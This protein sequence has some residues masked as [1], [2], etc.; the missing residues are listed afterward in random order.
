LYPPRQYLLKTKKDDWPTWVQKKQPQIPSIE[1]VFVIIAKASDFPKLGLQNF[2]LVMNTPL[3]DKVTIYGV[4][5][6][7]L[8]SWWPGALSREQDFIAGI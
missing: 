5:K 3:E 8:E 7:S 4:T 6:M 2:K 1:S